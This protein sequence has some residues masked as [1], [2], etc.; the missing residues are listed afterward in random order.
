[1]KWKA[2]LLFFPSWFKQKTKKADLQL[3][4]TS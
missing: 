1:M 2:M 4:E 3:G